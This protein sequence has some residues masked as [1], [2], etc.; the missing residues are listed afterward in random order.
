M[1]KKKA[2]L[3]DFA[4]A[5]EHL[6][7]GQPVKREGWMRG[8]HLEHDVQ[9]KLEAIFLRIGNDPFRSIWSPNPD[10]ILARDW[11]LLERGDIKR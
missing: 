9:P 3:H 5:L 11:V 1:K 4:S 8:Y 2:V 10:D 7:C 6:R